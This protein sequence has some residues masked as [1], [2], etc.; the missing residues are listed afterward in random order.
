[1]TIQETYIEFL[2]LVNRNAT[3]N[4]TNVDKPRFVM[5]FNNMQNKYLEW[6]LDKRNEDSIRNVQAVLVKNLNLTQ[7]GLEET[8]TNYALPENYFDF[9][10][11]TASVTTDCCEANNMLLFET[12]SEDVEEKLADT[13]TQ[14]SFEYRESFYHFSNNSVVLYKKG[15]EYSKVLLTYYRYPRQVDIAGYPKLDNTLSTDI[16]PE[17]DDKVVNRIL[18]AMSKEFSAI[19]SDANGYQITKDRLFTI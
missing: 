6:S 17:F 18:L 14:P 8:H 5:L 12:K 1:M 19:N 2:N 13:N 3:N 9:S 16:D 10:N 4:R 15:F 11:I 7:N